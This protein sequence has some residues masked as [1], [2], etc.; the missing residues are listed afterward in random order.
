MNNVISLAAHRSSAA[1][2]ELARRG[3]PTELLEV[4]AALAVAEHDLVMARAWLKRSRSN[5]GRARAHAECER[6]TQRVVAL[7][8]RRL[9]LVGAELALLPGGRK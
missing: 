6:L 7:E 2:A 1:R 4:D 5:A 9:R 8:A 3:F